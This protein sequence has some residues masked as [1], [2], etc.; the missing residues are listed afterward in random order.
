MSRA[1]GAGV[2]RRLISVLSRLVLFALLW[3]AITEGDMSTWSYAVVVV[4]AALATSYA[5]LPYRYRPPGAGWAR[6]TWA[7]IRLCGWF[8]RRSLSGGV[9]VARRALAPRV[10][11]APGFVRCL[12]RLP[13]G[14]GRVAVAD[15]MNLMPGS[16]SVQLDQDSHGADALV[17]HVL[18][19]ELPIPAT[20]A[21]LEEQIAVVAALPLSKAPHHD[22]APAGPEPS[23][24]RSADGASAVGPGS[25]P[26]APGDEPPPPVR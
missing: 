13:P 25:G 2:A 18:D 8:L 1:R 19:L 16:L 20:V 11:L 23:G 12:M 6:R 9:D 7:L 4:P 26:E 15:L 22:A 17:L 24:G 21:Q 14:G 5:L 3:W 10:D